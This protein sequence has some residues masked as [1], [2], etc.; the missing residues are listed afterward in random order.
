MALFDLSNSEWL[1]IAPCCRGAGRSMAV[2]VWMTERC[3]MASSLSCAPA[4]RGA[5]CRRCGPYTA[6]YNRFNLWAKKGHLAAHLREL[7]SPLATIVAA[8]RQ[9]DHPRSPTRRGLQ[10][11][12]R[13]APSAVLVEHQDQ[14]R[15]RSGRE[16]IFVMLSQGQ[17]FD[18]PLHRS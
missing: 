16:P 13:T 5:I 11:G 4:R 1:I 2:L 18:G 15:G 3:S 6:T 12:G 10:K 7:G 8:D 9:L 17:A 14:C